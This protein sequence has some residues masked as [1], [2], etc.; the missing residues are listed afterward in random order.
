MFVIYT[1]ADVRCLRQVSEVPHALLDAIEANLRDLH[2]TLGGT[3]PVEEFTLGANGPFAVILQ[4]GDGPGVY[5]LLPDGVP[6][7]RPEWVGSTAY[8]GTVVYQAIYLRG[9]DQAVNLFIPVGV[10]DHAAERQLA[11]AVAECI[12]EGDQ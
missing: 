9:N 1:L 5:E 7:S 2:R 12:E 4:Q 10:L 11:D 3:G 8:G 6:H